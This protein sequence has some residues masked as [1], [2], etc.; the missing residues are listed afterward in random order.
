MDGLASFPQFSN[1]P[2]LNLASSPP[3]LLV[4]GAQLHERADG[5]PSSSSTAQGHHKRQQS[6]GDQGG[7][8]GKK[9][10][11]SQATNREDDGQEEH[12][13]GTGAANAGSPPRKQRACDQ[14]KQQKV[15]MAFYF[16]SLLCFFTFLCSFCA[17]SHS[18][19]LD[20]SLAVTLDFDTLSRP[21]PGTSINVS[22]SSNV[23]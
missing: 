13:D 2:P 10:K 11:L 20:D 16:G 1:S 9:R 14:C 23:T 8:R 21:T 6:Q 3:S 17:G 7:R 15:R 19:R 5:R 22:Y 4:S 12:D 18:I